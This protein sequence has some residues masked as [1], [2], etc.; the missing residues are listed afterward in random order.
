MPLKK[1]NLKYIKR[2]KKIGKRFLQVFVILLV[3][4]SIVLALPSVQT[5][6]GKYATDYLQDEYD[7]DIEVNKIDL[8]FFGSVVLKEVLIKDHHKDTLINVEELESSVLSFSNIMR[9]KMQFGD[10]YLE[11][12]VLNIKTYENEKDD[13]LT[14]FAEKFDE[15]KVNNEPSGFKL[16]SEKLKFKNGFVKITDENKKD[17]KPVFYKIVSGAGENFVIDG[18]NVNVDVRD[19][20]FIENHNLYIENLS[21]DF[22]YTKTSMKIHNIDLETKTSKIIGNLNFNYKREDLADFNNKVNISGNI[23]NSSVSLLDLKNFYNE[24]GTQGSIL[25][26]T[27]ISGQLNNLDLI[28]FKSKF[29]DKGI[30]NGTFNV[31]N[32]F[33][34][35]NGFALDANFKNLTSNY[36]HLKTILPNILGKSLPSS[37]KQIGNFTLVGKTN[38]SNDLIDANVTIKSE[39]GTAISD[40]ELSNIS[41]IDNASYLG[42]IKIIDLELGKIVKDSLIGKL[43][44][45]ADVNGDG[46]TFDDINTTINGKIFKHQYKNYTYNNITVDG[47]LKNKHFNGEME[48]NDENIKL[49]FKGLADFSKEIYRFNFKAL[50]DYCD[51]NKLN[52]FKR[53]SISNIVGDIEIDLKGNS[54]DNLEGAINFTNSQ[55]I[56]QKDVYYFEDFSVTSSFKDSFR[57]IDINSPEIIKGKVV[58]N[59]KFSELDKLIQNSFG[60]IY[61]YYKPYDVNPNQKLNFHFD[62]YNKIVEVFFPEISLSANTKINGKIDS[63]KDLFI[64][65]IQSPKIIAYDNIINSINLQIN[66]KNPLFNTQLKIDK[67]KSNVYD[68]SKLHLINKTFNDTLYFGAEFYGGKRNTESYSLSFY[69]TFNKEN[70]SVFGINKSILNVKN[71]K[72]YINSE[73]NSENKIVYDKKNKKYLLSS[74]ELSSGTQKIIF[75]GDIVE[76]VSKDLKFDFK[77]VNLADITPNIDSLNLQGK[78][79]GKLNYTQDKNHIKPTVDMLLSN[80]YVNNSLQGDLNMKIEG[81]NSI[82]EYVVDISLKRNDEVNF[83]ANGEIDFSTPKAIIDV[84]VDFVEFKLDAFSP[85]GEDVFNNIRGHAYGN[86]NLS[87]LLKNPTME[88][89]L[90]LDEA[91]MFFPYINVDYNFVGTSVINL[92]DQTFTFYDVQLQDVKEESL[93]ELTGIIRHKN[94]DNWFLDLDVSTNN[95][96]V[97][98]TKESETSLYYGKGFFEGLATIK[99]FTDKLTIDIAGKTKKGTNFIVPISDI[100]TAESSELIRFKNNNVEDQEENEKIRREFISDKLKG[101]NMNFNLEVTKDAIFKMVVDKATGSYL[102]GSGTGNLQIEVD[103]K[104]KFDMY[105]DFIVDNGVY[106]FK[107]GAIVNKPFT[108]KKGGTI[109][110]SGDPITADINI[111]AV[112]IVSA[113][114]KTILENINTNRKIPVNLITRFSGELFNS[115]REFDIEIPNSSSTVASELNFKIRNNETIQFVTLLLSGNFYNQSDESNTSNSIL[116]GTGADLLSNTMDNLLNDPNSK[117]RLKPVYTLGD[118]NDVNSIESSD[119]LAID[120]DYQVNDKIFINGK[121][122]VPIGAK[123]QKNIIG[124]VTVE[125]LLNESGTL[126]SSVFNRQN[127]IQYTIEEEGYTQGVGLS[128]QIDFDNG[129]ELL[130]K[131][132]LKKRTVKDT[133]YNKKEIDTINNKK[134]INFINKKNE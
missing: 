22:E 129:K 25:L 89:D 94:F 75:S 23:E 45:E 131:L 99:G 14:V 34:L 119:Q 125:F 76:G 68:I 1:T 16:T 9:N 65:N 96:L 7:V 71:N 64:V 114:P 8:S 123:E 44:M 11:N 43:S 93:A 31:K 12:F 111:E 32:L 128:Y 49:N 77:N 91:G 102:Q 120:M 21:T 66:N 86:V 124:E 37:F 122:S 116:Y 62:I 133:V 24:I 97:L 27:K 53:D 103:T 47:K 5:K 41:D 112:N 51:L 13:A 57:T 52:L 84:D 72:W 73:E 39:I 113:N 60:S 46:F 33:E 107:Y 88:G 63:N 101:L 38:I 59:F 2:I 54:A 18:P 109:S 61:T 81:K 10:I 3:I 56:N 42:H 69:H 105:G 80:F 126:R 4:S 100:K 115:K 104:D 87:G 58:G 90:F 55:Y 6:L 106:M 40:L 85:L 29:E 118:R 92:K 110:W 134:I 98:D 35:E 19:F 28:D 15:E 78:V 82:K 132:K 70:K 30:I 130:E 121:M 36:K 79:N 127:D 20:N 83:S 17:E 74:F 67:V 26:S 117:F 50:V 48:V 108:M 95:L